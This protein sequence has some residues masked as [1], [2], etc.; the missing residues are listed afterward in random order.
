MK[1][2]KFTRKPNGIYIILLDNGNEHQLYEE[3]ILKYGLLLTKKI[4]EQELE[5]I[6]KE[7]KKW[8]SY[9]QALKLLRKTIKTKQEIYIY[10]KEKD[11]DKKDIE[12]NINLLEKQGYLNDSIYSKSYINNQI[13]TTSKGPKN[14]IL[15]LEKKG[16]EKEDYQEAIEEYTIDIQKEKIEKIINKKIKS[17]HNKSNKNL[18]QKIEKDIINLGYDISIIK[19]V[20][21]DTTFQNDSEIAKKE[22]QKQYNKLSRKYEGKEL[23]YKLKQKMYSLGFTKYEE[24]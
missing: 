22:Y 8:E 23:E 2:T 10:L 24:N 19:N 21:Q 7:N 15:E 13:L 5:N 11:Y 9:Y 18:K 14:I 12:E 6:L 3:I 20:L 17:N 1:I 16:V 4:D